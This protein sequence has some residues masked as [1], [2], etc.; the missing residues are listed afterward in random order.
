MLGAHS[1]SDR[2]HVLIP[3][4]AKDADSKGAMQFFPLRLAPEEL[5][6]CTPR[7]QGRRLL[8]CSPLLNGYSLAIAILLG[9]IKDEGW[10]TG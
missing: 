1:E 9:L 8:L 5:M 6:K 3:P 4:R 7:L 10:L 2:Y